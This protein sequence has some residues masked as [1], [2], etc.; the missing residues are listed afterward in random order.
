MDYEKAFDYA[1]RC[2]LISKLMNNGCGAQFTNAVAKMYASTSYIPYVN[3]KL[4]DEIETSSGVAQGRNSS[5]DLYSFYVS[6]MPKCTDSIVTSDFMDPNI[7][8]QLAD[9]TAL[10]A[11][12]FASF[13]EKTKCLLDYSS[14]NYQVPNIPKTVFCHFAA[15][16]TLSPM[17]I[18]ENISI[19]SVDPQKGHR[20]LGMKYFPTNIFTGIVKFNMNDRKGKICKFYAWLEDSSDT[21]IEIKLLVLDNCLF[22]SLLY[23]V[24]TWGNIEC[25]EKDLR[26]ME[27]KALRAILRVKAGT[28]TDMLYNELKRADI[29]SKVKDSQFEFYKKVK[30]FTEEDAMVAAILKLCKDTSIVR[31]YDALHGNNRERNITER[32]ERITTSNASM[33]IYYRNLVDIINKP[34][35]YSTFMNDSQRHTI[36]RWRLSNHKLQVEL[37]RYAVPIIPREERICTR[38]NVLED[39]YHAIYVCPTFH[40]LRM[41][42]DDVMIKYNSVRALLNPEYVDVYQVA[43]FL[44]DIDD[45]LSKR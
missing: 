4:G 26:T 41:K 13:K 3:N 28:T 33:M 25:I 7:I 16:P 1:N 27:H 18:D 43:N 38:C 30:S 21:P 37:G 2:E 19:S 11:E 8:A 14:A 31:Y 22:L 6:D 36:T 40:L 5:P 44:H 9:D 35:I 23:G 29:M 10:L 34:I 39:E 17:I 32:Q 12:Q 45:V 20:Y 15:N 24:E 42:Y